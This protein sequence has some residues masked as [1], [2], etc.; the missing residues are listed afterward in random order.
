MDDKFYMVL[1]EFDKTKWGSYYDYYVRFLNSYKINVI[2]TADL[3]TFIY[4]LVREVE[5]EKANTSLSSLLEYQESVSTDFTQ[6]LLSAVKLGVEDLFISSDIRVNEGVLEAFVKIYKGPYILNKEPFNIEIEGSKL[7]HEIGL[8]IFD[9]TLQ[10]VKENT[11]LAESLDF[12]EL[13]NLSLDF[14]NHTRDFY[15]VETRLERFIELSKLVIENESEQNVTIGELMYEVLGYC[16]PTKYLTSNPGGRLLLER[17]GDV[18]EYHISNYLGYVK[19]RVEK[20]YGINS[21]NLYWIQKLVSIYNKEDSPIRITL[22]NILF[23][24]SEDD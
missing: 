8:G 20:D 13:T 3:P 17:L 24:L 12:V 19:A 1:T 11:S 22:D 16:H 6:A 15:W 2:E 7:D 21:T 5:F 23:K 9:Y 10:L 4:Q 18:S 14:V